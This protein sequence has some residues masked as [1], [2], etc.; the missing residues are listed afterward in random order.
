[1]AEPHRVLLARD[2][3]EASPDAAG[4]DLVEAVRAEVERGERLVVVAGRGCGVGPGAV[5]V[6]RRC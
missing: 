6:S 5:Q 4:D 2:D 3:L 1:V